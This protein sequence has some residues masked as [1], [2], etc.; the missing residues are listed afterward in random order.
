[1]PLV[2]Y[3]ALRLGLFAVALVA[4]AATGLGDWLLVLVAAVAAWAVS[5]VAFPRQREAAVAWMARRSESRREAGVRFTAGTARDEAEEDAVVDAVRSAADGD[6]VAGPARTEA[7]RTVTGSTVTGSTAT[8]STATGSTAAGTTAV[9]RA[10]S[11]P[12]GPGRPA[13]EGQAES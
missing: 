6:A 5:Y 13:S 1:M 2:V 11:D 3:T 7:D 4:L 9:G 10:P 12:A 8:G